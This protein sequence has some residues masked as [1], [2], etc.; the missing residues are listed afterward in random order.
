MIALRFA[1]VAPFALGAL[2]AQ[3]PSPPAPTATPSSAA[4][5]GADALTPREIA[6]QA[7]AIG[8]LPSLLRFHSGDALPDFQVLRP[9]GTTAKF[10]EVRTGAAIVLLLPSIAEQ[11]PAGELLPLAKTVAERYAPHGV[12]T[13]VFGLW[14]QPDAFAAA[15]RAAAGKW[16]FGVFGDP[17]GT[18][19]GPADDE[20]ARMA[21]HRRTTLGTMFGGGMTPPLPAAFVVGADGRLAGSFRPNAKEIPFDGIGNLLLRAGVKLTG[22]DVPGVLAPAALWQKPPERAPEAPVTLVQPGT[23]APDFAMVDAD[24]KPVR[25]AD[26]QGKIVVLDFWATWCGPCKAAL[27]HVQE[28]AAKY[29]AQG[30]VVVASC[31]ND[32]REE[33][34]EFVRANQAK[35]PD[36]QLAFDPK[37][38]SPERAS[39]TLYGVSGIPQQ[40][41]IGKDGVIASAVDGYMQGEVL[42]DA[43]LAVAGVQV[44]AAILEQAKADRKKR[45]DMAS[46]RKAALPLKPVGGDK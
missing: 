21:H 37:E 29:K 6:R 18:Y 32:G 30:V 5:A 36:V 42:L 26:H 4:T 14:M 13:F 12:Q 17:A 23:K 31:T 7:L 40:F 8:F 46:K 16:P 11:P 25:L 35:Y 1:V 44:D 39:R 20:N 33:F 9:D 3:Q 43:A 28:V 34:V 41:V 38:R 10:G 19:T 2:L 22:K 24:G 27:P 15:A 45:D